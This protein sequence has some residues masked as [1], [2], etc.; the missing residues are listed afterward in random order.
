MEWR[1]LSKH[2]QEQCA[3]LTNSTINFCAACGDLGLYAFRSQRFC[4]IC[5]AELK[6]GVVVNQN[7]TFVGNRP[8]GKRGNP[9]PWQEN[10]VRLLED[11]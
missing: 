6:T 7:L 1:E 10:A 3:D 8:V 4:L 2:E 5:Y 11:C 9:S